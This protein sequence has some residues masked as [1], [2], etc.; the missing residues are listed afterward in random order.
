MHPGNVPTCLE[1]LSQIEEMLIAR[2]CPIMCAFRLKGGQRGYSGHVLN[3]PQ[4]LQGFLDKLPCYI[5]DLPVILIRRHGCDNTH[6]DCRV[7]RDHVLAALLWLKQNNPFYKNI[8]INLSALNAL[9]LDGIPENILDVEEQPQSH[10]T[11]EVQEE[12]T[13]GTILLAIII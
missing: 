5:S 8:E 10:Y 11:P 4:D 1:G 2:A 3:L 6:K 12:I 13:T 7:R 9:P